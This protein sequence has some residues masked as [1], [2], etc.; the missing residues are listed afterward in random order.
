ML[1]VSGGVYRDHY[2]GILN[3]EQALDFYRVLGQ[4]SIR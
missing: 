4:R 1:E 2:C 3:T